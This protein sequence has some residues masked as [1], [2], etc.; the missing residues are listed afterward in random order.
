LEAHEVLRGWIVTYFGS[1]GEDFVCRIIASLIGIGKK[2][3]L[4]DDSEFW[5]Q[6]TLA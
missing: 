6:Q 3:Q 4:L 2:A 1:L 5:V